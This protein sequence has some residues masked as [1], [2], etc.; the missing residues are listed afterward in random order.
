M[1]S[2]KFLDLFNNKSQFCSGKDF[3]DFPRFSWPVFLIFPDHFCTKLNVSGEDLEHHFWETR[4]LWNIILK[5]LDLSNFIKIHRLSLVSW[6]YKKWQLRNVTQLGTPTMNFCMICMSQIK[7]F[8]DQE[9]DCVLRDTLY[10]LS[11]IS[12]DSTS[13]VR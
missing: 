11:T 12:T 6:F 4:R 8:L 3:P 9:N 5:F 1:V 10:N 13:W 7:R 2:L